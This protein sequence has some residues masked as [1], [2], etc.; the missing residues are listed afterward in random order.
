MFLYK[1]GKSTEGRDLYS[2]EI[3]VQSDRDKKVFI[4]AG[5]H[6]S[7]EFAGGIFL[8]KQFADLIQKAQRD[9]ATMELL[10]QNKY[11]AVP[12][13]SVDVREALIHMPSKWTINGELWKAYS[14]G[15]DG[16]RN[17]PGLQWGQIARGNYLESTIMFYPAYGFYAGSH[18]G[19]SMETKAMMKWVYH[20]VVIEKA[21]CYLDYHQ[22]GRS[23]YAGCHW[24]TKDQFETSMKLVK[25][26]Q[27]VI[28]NKYGVSYRYI[29][30][31]K[32]YGLQGEGSASTDYSIAL[33][34]G[35]K[36][37]PAY[38]FHVFPYEGKE[39]TLME[40]VDLDRKSIEPIVANSKFAAATIEIGADI[41]Y[42]GYDKNARNLIA[43][44][45]YNYNFDKLLE[46]LPTFN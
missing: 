35:A 1:I 32:H 3:D 44:E 13:V 9:P 39:Y 22:K 6:H 45:Y 46:K 42:L 16:N 25:N 29:P 41:R 8:L 14:N 36:F 17:Y 2:I 19:S 5:Q 23:I 38:G 34:V 40:I 31:Q 4:F 11:V 21:I 26:L 27:S 28:R 15:T 30:E 12:I 10:K 20:Y 24:Q 43:S 33:A 18:G 37:S 7:R